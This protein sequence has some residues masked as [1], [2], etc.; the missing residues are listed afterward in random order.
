MDSGVIRFMHEKFVDDIK[1]LAQN[2]KTFGPDDLKLLLAAKKKEAPKN[3]GVMAAALTYA[4]RLGLIEPSGIHA[5]PRWIGTKS[6]RI[7]RELWK[8]RVG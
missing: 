7:A 4:W 3:G 2:L 5:K 6:Y 8:G 1:F